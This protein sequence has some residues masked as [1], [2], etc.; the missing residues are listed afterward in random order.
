M[1]VNFLDVSVSTVDNKPEVAL[2]CKPTDRHQPFHF[3]S[4]HP[5]HKT[6]SIVCRKGLRIKRLCSSPLTSPKH[7]EHLKAWF[8]KRGY[9]QKIVDVQF[10]RV[11]EKSLDGLF[12]RPGRK[13]Q[14][15]LLL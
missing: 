4:P 7:L 1:S 12:E 14:V 15:Y 2:F 11:S 9:P 13:K 3:N 8:C 6:K 10:K 5:F